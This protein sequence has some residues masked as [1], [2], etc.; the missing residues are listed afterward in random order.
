[1]KF[2]RA[3]LR[4]ILA[5]LMVYVVPA[6]AATW[7]DATGPYPT[8]VVVDTGPD[9]KYYMYRPQTLRPNAHP[10]AVFCGGAGSHPRDYDALL[11]SLASHGVVVISSTE[12][13]QLDGSKANAG[14]NWLIEQHEKESGEYFQKL[15]PSKV[16]AIG[17]SL[18]GNGAVVASLR[19]SK[20]RSLL[21]Y[22][23][24]L[25]LAS[26]RDLSVPA[27]YISGSLDTTIPAKFVRANYEDA[28]KAT[29]WYG[30]NT[31]QGHTGFARNPSVQYYTRAWVYTHLFGDSGSARGCFYGPDWTFKNASTWADQSKN[32]SA[33]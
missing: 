21:L 5:I 31:N 28:T 19:N 24:S 7:E 23:P 4:L 30:E 14:V 12:S 3:M 29:A 25:E 1:M 8:T 32:N 2:F 13:N 22:S 9:G 27:F 11:A 6:C 26:S 16:L 33:L 15:I 17:H 18:G 20:I 10:I